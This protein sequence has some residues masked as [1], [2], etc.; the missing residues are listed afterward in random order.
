MLVVTLA[1]SAKQVSKAQF[2]SSHSESFFYLPTRYLFSESSL[3]FF[4]N[5]TLN[6]EKETLH[7][8][9]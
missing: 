9:F 4:T 7:Q 2:Y 8:T 1:E 5:E 6:P 3:R